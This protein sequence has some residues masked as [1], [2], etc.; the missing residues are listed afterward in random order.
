MKIFGGTQAYRWAFHECPKQLYLWYHGAEAARPSLFDRLRFER[1]NE[2]EARFLDSA[3]QAAGAYVDIRESRW[4]DR[5]AATQ[6]A[7]RDGVDLILHPFL[8]AEPD[9]SVG[10]L[11]IRVAGEAD[12]LRRIKAAGTPVYETVEVKQSSKVLPHHLAQVA[13]YTLAQQRGGRDAPDSAVVVTWQR[14]EDDALVPVE[15]RVEVAQEQRELSRFLREDVPTIVAD[16]DPDYHLRSTCDQCPYRARCDRDA[17]HEQHLSLLPR[18]RRRQRADLLLAGVNT[19]PELAV[20]PARFEVVEKRWPGTGYAL[21]SLRTQALAFHY[22]RAF[23]MGGLEE[24]LVD[25][26][27]WKLAT[28]EG[29][30]SG[31]RVYFDLET[32]PFANNTVYLFGFQVEL[33]KCIAPSLTKGMSEA[34]AFEARLEAFCA[35][36]GHLHAPVQNIGIGKTHERDLFEDFLNRMDALREECGRLAI[37]HYGRFEVSNL[38]ALAERHTTVPDADERVER[39]VGE[40]VDILTALTSTRT[41][42]VTSFSLK[43]VAPAL[44]RISNGMF[45]RDWSG[46]RTRPE[47]R[48][49]LLGR[50]F[51]RTETLDAIASA[52]QAADHWRVPIEE[53][54]APSAGNSVVWYREYLADQSSALWPALITAYNEDDLL[55]LREVTRWLASEHRAKRRVGIEKE[56]GTAEQMR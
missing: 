15:N 13:L 8:E 47:L 46:P 39:L 51:S 26:P 11:G 7:M 42:P 33:S 53:I 45:G 43:R 1:G 9:Q 30:L 4:R 52:A 28:G 56:A 38:R 5:V 48:D 19:W 31:A 37:I 35:Q 23:A 6:A 29:N 55:A 54:L 10:Q 2:L 24:S 14:G 3:K 36:H 18:I 50:A 22:D 49:F 41:L 17:V 40:S 32:D 34:E 21:R 16:R 25:N 20:D 27:A 44:R 12:A